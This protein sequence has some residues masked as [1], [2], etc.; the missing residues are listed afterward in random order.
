MKARPIH[1]LLIED[2]SSVAE[3]LQAGFAEIEGHSLKLDW[4]DTLGAGLRR[5]DQ[6]GIDVVLL[7]LS[8]PDS[9]GL[10]TY[11]QLRDA[12]PDLPVVILTG[13]EDEALGLQAVREGAQDYLIKGT[14][15]VRVLT[16]VLRYAIERKSAEESLREREEFFR[17]I[18]ESMTDLI[19]V[20][21]RQGRRIYNS[22]SYKRL[23]GDPKGQQGSVSFMEVHPDDRER[24]QEVFR[25]TLETGQGERTE[26]RFV[27][28]GGAVRHVESQGSVIFDKQGKPEKVVVISRDITERKLAEEG[29]RESEQRYMRL[30]KSTTD[31]IYSTGMENGVVVETT[32]GPGCQGVTGYQPQ[33]YQL[34]PGLWL[35]MVHDE[36]REQVLELVRQV[37]SGLTAAPL[38]HRIRRKDGKVR[39]VRHTPVLRRD[40][41]RRLVGYDGL[42]SDIT[43]KREAEE[44]LRNSQALYHS[45]VETLPQSIFRKD[46][47]GR[48]TFVNNHFCRDMQH[49][50]EALLGRTD[51]DFSPAEVAAGYRADDRKVMDTGE[52]LDTVERFV[53]A[54]GQARFVHVMKTPVHDALGNCIG[55]Q[56]IFYDVT[57]ERRKEEALAESEARLQAILDN[58]TAVVYMKDVEGRYVLVNRTYENIFHLSREQILGR[59]DQDLFPKELADA[60]RE[61]DHKVLNSPTPI[62]FEEVALLDDGPHTYISIKFSLRDAAGGCY[63]TCGVST[64]ITERK[65][66]EAA[67]Q[68]TNAELVNSQQALM[69]ALAD[70]QRS[71]EEL[72]NTQLQLIQVEKMESIG[73]LAAGVAHEVKNPLQTIVMGVRYLSKVLGDEN[74]TIAQVVGD[75]RDAAARADVIVKGLLEFSAPRELTLS[76]ESLNDILRASLKLV[77]YAAND[78]GITIVTEL[79]GQLPRITLDKAKIEQVFLN[80][81]MNAIQAMPDG[82]TLTVRTEVRFLQGGELAA[83][84]RGGGEDPYRTGQMVIAAEVEDTGHGIPEDKLTRIFDPF[85]TTKPVGKGTGLGLTVVQ[86]IV[87]LNGGVIQIRNRPEGGVRASIIFKPGKGHST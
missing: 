85:F 60:F 18:S 33:D 21:D 6:G 64:D 71:H 74:P 42:I 52:T 37:Q 29:L 10:D 11:R 23:L 36:D 31:Y 45:L 87:E 26:Y 80:L 46:A 30:L 3:M 15:V 62:E 24:I 78:H 47:E 67:L 19:A 82:G 54:D 65:R 13:S 34:D 59:R 2:S 27:T 32:H 16:R 63:A 69:Q 56:G 51:F 66:A 14:L 68:K 25:R 9:T 77:N 1:I 40:Q 5:V 12:A 84:D 7:D 28:P 43:E 76:R 70:L 53:T 55:I 20:V 44:Q 58:T 22:P 61:N 8:L 86:K 79:A 41:E 38:E 50:A 57:E 83:S 73:G 72:K 4:A 39:W 49:P 75:I 81:L 17:L 48:F 35:K